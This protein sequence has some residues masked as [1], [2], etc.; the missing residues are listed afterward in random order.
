MRA[1]N[2]VEGRH[3][4]LNHN[5]RRAKLPMYV[6]INLLHQESLFVTLQARLLSENKLK[7]QQHH[8]FSKLQAKVSKYW[9]KFVEGDRTTKQLLRA[10]LYLNGPS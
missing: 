4:R 6:L 10:C 3:R 2:D 8:K 9:E 7:R 5:A 1:N